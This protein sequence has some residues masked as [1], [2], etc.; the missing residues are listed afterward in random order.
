MIDLI[1]TLFLAL[2]LGVS[3]AFLFLPTKKATWLQDEPLHDTIMQMQ[4][5]RKTPIERLALRLQ[6]AQVSLSVTRY[7]AF[8]LTSGLVTYFFTG[9]ILQSWWLSL[10]ALLAGILFTE[11]FV[12]ILRV[13]YRERFEE[14]NVRA[15]R[16][17]AS[18][19]RTSPSY[20]HAFEQVA[21]SPFVDS[22]VATEYGRLVEFLRGQIPL[23]TA[24]Q[25]MF[26]RTG[27]ADIAYLATIVQVQ[28]QLGGDMAKTLDLASATIIRRKQA[29]RRQRATMS[30]V[31]AQ[32]N[33]LSVMPFVFVAILYFNN[34]HH[35]EPLTQAVWGRFAMLGSFLSIILG[36]EAIRYMSL[37]PLQKGG[38]KA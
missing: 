15:L 8:A 19:L 5:R 34:P 20:L 37:N 9:L 29:Q 11:R 36:G 28:R 6:Q 4:K 32:V 22:R 38:E 12:S 13:R 18:S 31:L 35:F 30:Q 7:F 23:E 3:G 14:G 27:S 10:P 21:Q 25:H 26:Q 33:M 16:I 1:I 2:T 24:M 17:M